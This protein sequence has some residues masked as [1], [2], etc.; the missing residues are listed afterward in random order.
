MRYWFFSPT[1]PLH[2]C[3]SKHVTHLECIFIY[4]PPCQY[5]WWGTSPLQ[6]SHG[7]QAS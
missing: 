3:I 2:I 5:S 1:H 4:P 7:E 6:W